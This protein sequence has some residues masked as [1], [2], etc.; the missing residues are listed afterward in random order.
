MTI[1]KAMS[2]SARDPYRQQATPASRIQGTD[3]PTPSVGLANDWQLHRI[4]SS[5]AT[6]SPN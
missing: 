3:T 5:D 1:G 2:S 6:A 4:H